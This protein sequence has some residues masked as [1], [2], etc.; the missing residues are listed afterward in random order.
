MLSWVEHEKTF[1]TSG[2]GLIGKL[3]IIAMGKQSFNPFMPGGCFYRN[4]LDL[5]ISKRRG[6]FYITMFDRNSNI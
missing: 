2:P 4:S 5:F 6:W 1:I 3:V